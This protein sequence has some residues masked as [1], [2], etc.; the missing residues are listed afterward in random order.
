MK[1]GVPPLP[2]GSRGL[3]V[4]LLPYLETGD[5]LRWLL[6]GGRLQAVVSSGRCGKPGTQE[7]R[8]M[9]GAQAPRLSG[10]VEACNMRAYL[11]SLILSK[12]ED[13]LPV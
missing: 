6:D 11:G 9:A 3:A 10:E 8:Q 5:W 7:A 13:E 4:T 1:Y 2:W 12:V